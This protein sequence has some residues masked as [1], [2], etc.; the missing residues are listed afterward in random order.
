MASW[1]ADDAFWD[2]FAPYF[3]TP[4]RVERAAAEVKALV[5][6]LRINSGASV[7]DLCCGI[8]RHSVE[9]ARLGYVVTAVDLT[10]PFLARARKRAESE[11]VKLEFVQADMR[12]FLRAAAFDAAVN[13]VTSFG[14][15]EDQADDLKAARN[16]YES[17]KPGARLAMEMMGKET[18]ARS[19]VQ[20]QWDTAP[21]GTLVLM[22]HKLRSGWDWIDNRWIIVKG[23]DRR[24]LDFSC[25]LYSA[26]ELGAV[27]RQGGFQSVEFFGTLD[28]APY[29]QNAERLVAV[30]TK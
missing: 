20:R 24:E 5:R 4:E 25:R 29:D 13:L 21:D 26:A 8:G 2:A 18:L 16:L 27:L 28:G 1:W 11:K 3:F 9:F 15:F 14:Y 12:D 17:L 6:L 23:A 10:A 7:L 30:A 22:E 19:F